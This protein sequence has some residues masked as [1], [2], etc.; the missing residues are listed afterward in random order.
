MIHS[1]ELRGPALQIAGDRLVQNTLIL[2]R[3]VSHGGE[4]SSLILVPFQ[5]TGTNTSLLKEQMRRYQHWL[6]CHG[7]VLILK[8]IHFT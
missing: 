3:I 1:K 7:P 2:R 4:G 8:C 6:Y 5:R